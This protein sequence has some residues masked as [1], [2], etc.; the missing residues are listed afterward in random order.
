MKEI[1]SAARISLGKTTIKN[2]SENYNSDEIKNL[3]Q[4]K[5]VIKNELKFA[6]DNISSPKLIHLRY[7]FKF[8]TIR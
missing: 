3:R 6:Q 4:N 1:D 5:R 7:Y 2:K 8:K